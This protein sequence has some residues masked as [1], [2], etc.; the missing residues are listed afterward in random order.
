VQALIARCLDTRSFHCLLLPVISEVPCEMNLSLREVS[1]R[2]GRRTPLG[3]GGWTDGL[4]NSCTV[5]AK[6]A[7][8]GLLCSLKLCMQKTR[9]W[10][11]LAPGPGLPAPDPGSRHLLCAGPA[12]PFY[13]FGK[14]G[15]PLWCYPFPTFKYMEYRELTLSF[16]L[17]QVNQY[18]LP[19]SLPLP[20]D[21][22]RNRH[23]TQWVLVSVGTFVQF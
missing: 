23:L 2:G 19:S 22:F 13:F 11:D 4:F 1:P 5:G 7:Q 8:K 17:G 3:F 12:P 6:A 18:V 10:L 15:F 21:W 16:Q 20:D 14:T 9:G